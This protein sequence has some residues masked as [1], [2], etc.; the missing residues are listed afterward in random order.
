MADSV[1]HEQDLDAI[2]GVNSVRDLVLTDP[3]AMRA[4]ADPI[5]LTLLDRLRREGPATAADLSAQ[6]QVTASEI[7]DHL[8][9]LETFGIVA[10]PEVA[11]E[12]HWSAV[13][14][15]FVFEIPNDPEGQAAARRLSS[16]MLLHYVDLPRRWVE[17]DE[18]RLELEWARA[19]GLLNARVTVTADEL[20]G[21]Q[22]ELERL[23][24]PFITRESDAVPAGAAPVRVLAYFMPEPGADQTARSPAR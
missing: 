15:G 8:R 5:R 23:L 20:R 7:Q 12:S 22:R 9:E 16:V 17:A 21:L 10:R 13:A 24:E 3:Q 2:V 11:E 1:D 19:A 18:P 6:I 14:N 4:L